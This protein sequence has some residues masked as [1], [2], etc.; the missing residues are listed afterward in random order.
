MRPDVR[1]CAESQQGLQGEDLPGDRHK[2][3]GTERRELRESVQP[4]AEL[5]QHACITH[6]VER[7]GMNAE[8]LVRSSPQ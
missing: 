4:A 1:L 2:V 7:L 6:G 8:P 3:R 5:L